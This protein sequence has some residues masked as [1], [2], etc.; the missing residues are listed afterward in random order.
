[1]SN[2]PGSL[3]IRNRKTCDACVICDSAMSLNTIGLYKRCLAYTSSESH[4]PDSRVQIVVSR[5]QIADFRSHIPDHKAPAL[6]VRPRARP[7]EPGHTYI[8]KLAR[9]QPLSG[10]STDNTPCTY[11][12]YL[13]VQSCHALVSV[14]CLKC[15][16]MQPWNSSLVVL[17]SLPTSRQIGVLKRLCNQQTT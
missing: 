5:L 10:S 11:W 6:F 12:S 15:I 14:V 9:D 7:A 17:H 8:H 2:V 3:S 13:S 1:M 4:I 16:E